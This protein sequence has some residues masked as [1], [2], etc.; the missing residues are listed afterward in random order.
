MRVLQRAFFAYF[1]VLFPPGIRTCLAATSSEALQAGG[2]KWQY[3]VV[4]PKS[5]NGSNQVPL[6]LI[7]HGAGGRG[8][9][10]LEAAGW[11]RKADE[12]GFIA[13]APTS[14]PAHP[15][16]PANFRLNP[17]VWNTTQLKNLSER[18]KIDDIA[19]FNTLLETMERKYRIDPQRIF[20]TGHSNGAGMAFRL[21]S[22]IPDKIRA[23]APVMGLN[24]QTG[25]NPKSKVATL[26][27]LGR[28]DPLIPL[29]GGPR[30]TPWG[31]NILPPVWQGIERRAQALGCSTQY[32]ESHPAEN[33]DKRTYCAPQKNIFVVY[34]LEGQGHEWP[35]EAGRMLPERITGPKIN[36]F[37]ATDT[38]WA[39]FKSQE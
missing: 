26:Y 17:N 11:T 4:V 7:L 9:R 23:I 36:N 22:A 33:V 24:W 37:S 25:V 39:F 18:T 6:V 13:V 34:L 38:I 21:A 16:R 3:S 1:L 20:V 19:F 5:Y 2:Y 8:D 35:G 10:Y 27:I 12:E 32:E 15:D 31:K 29:N 14:A 28:N 30:T